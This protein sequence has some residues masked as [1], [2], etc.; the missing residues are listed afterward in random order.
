MFFEVNNA[1]F[2]DH[3]SLIA[4][5]LLSE[6]KNFS[7]LSEILKKVVGQVHVSSKSGQ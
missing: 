2:G 4:C 7:D 6:S 3:F 5:E 1:L